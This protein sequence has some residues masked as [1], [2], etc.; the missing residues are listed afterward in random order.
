MAKILSGKDFLRNALITIYIL[1]VLGISA[2]SKAAMTIDPIFT[3]HAQVQTQNF[4]G[5]LAM[6]ADQKFY[7]VVSNDEYYELQ[8]NID[9]ID[10]VG[11]LVQV[12][13]YELKHKVGPVVLTASLDPLP[14]SNHI[15]GAPVLIV[16][17][18]SEVVK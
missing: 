9:L 17:G 13:G 3:T 10:Y 16:F 8:A 12:E 6:S 18:I 4:V 11:Q 1:I 7:L 15:S 14:E 2:T 5:E